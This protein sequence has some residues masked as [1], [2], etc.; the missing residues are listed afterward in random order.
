MIGTIVE[1]RQYNKH[2]SDT[3]HSLSYKLKEIKRVKGAWDNF[4]GYVPLM[5]D[6]SCESVSLPLCEDIC[7]CSA[8]SCKCTTKLM[9]KCEIILAC[10]V[11]HDKK[12]TVTC[13][14][15]IDHIP[16]FLSDLLI[17]FPGDLLQ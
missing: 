1:I 16:V 3:Y 14:I 13:K 4:G 17:T 5:A 10:F 15:T 7:E 11:S 8:L 12:I 2:D 6:C 9:G